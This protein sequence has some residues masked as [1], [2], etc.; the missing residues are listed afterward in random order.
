MS[1][2][3]II[4]LDNNSTVPIAKGV[5][6]AM[7][8]YL[9]DMYANPS[10]VYSF[11]QKIRIT[12][13]EARKTVANFVNVNSSNIT[14]TSSG[15]EAN[16]QAI[17]G[18]M[19][20][21]DK[22]SNK[23]H[24][25]TTAIE[26]KSVIESCVFLEQH[27]FKVTYLKSD[28]TG[29]VNLEELKQNLKQNTALIS[30]MSVNNETGV[31]Q[32]VREISE[33]AK[34]NKILF[35]TDA[36][37]L[38][39]K[40]VNNKFLKDLGADLIT[41]SSHKIG[42][43]KGAGVLISKNNTVIPR[44]IYGGEQER[45]FRGGTENVA[46]IIGFAKACEL[47]DKINHNQI[48]KIENLR[49]YLEEKILSEIKSSIVNGNNKRIANTSNISFI[50][51]SAE[52]IIFSLDMYGV[53]VSSGAAC[54]SGSL[55]SSHVLKAMGLAQGRIDSAIRFSLGNNTSKNE[56]DKTVGILKSIVQ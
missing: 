46:S 41:L 36:V 17:I 6:E 54:S 29:S 49:D 9:K 52:V 31:L 30:V 27:G 23:N 10:T 35:H 2:K 12:L 47:N 1:V 39:S 42:G 44:F 25:I 38:A 43:P 4:Y 22:N 53:C 11:G 19:F 20:S 24:I 33:I 51:T 37:Q 21:L 7:E 45:G 28:E 34:E 14:F 32:P 18:T 5:F 50:G 26:H 56:I 48:K 40:S 8:P 15:T 13:E 55:D 3:E 16:N